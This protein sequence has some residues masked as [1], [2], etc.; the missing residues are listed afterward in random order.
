[1]FDYLAKTGLS[2]EEIEANIQ[3][4]FDQATPA[5]IAQGVE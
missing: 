2:K 4:V 5:M 3:R 1:M